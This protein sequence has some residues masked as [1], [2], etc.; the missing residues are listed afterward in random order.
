MTYQTLLIQNCDIERYSVIGEDD[1]GWPLQT[2][3]TLHPSI[4]CRLVFGK[5]TEIK[6]GQE[7]Y[8]VHN[9]LFLEDVDVT[10]Q[11]RVLLEGDYW[12]IVDVGHYSDAIGPHHKKLFVQKVT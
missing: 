9:E 5:G 10:T 8:I 7:V 2:W 12:N 6:V 3:T 11:D 4:P 1:A